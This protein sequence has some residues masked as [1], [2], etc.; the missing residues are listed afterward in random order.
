MTGG[1]QSVA[2]ISRFFG[3]GYGGREGGWVRALFGV[4]GGRGGGRGKVRWG[5][6]DGKMMYGDGE[7]E[8]KGLNSASSG[9]VYDVCGSVDGR[10]PVRRGWGGG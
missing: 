2:A 6:R 10:L 4:R 8:G 5:Y 1:L 7:A 9:F 3:S